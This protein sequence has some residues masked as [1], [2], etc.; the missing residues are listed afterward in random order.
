MLPATRLSFYTLESSDIRER[1]TTLA[2]LSGELAGRLPPSSR[3]ALSR[4]LEAINSYYSNMIEGQGTR[5][6]EAERALKRNLADRK[7]WKAMIW[8]RSLSP[9]SRPSA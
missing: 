9:K 3:I 8:R 6:I 2:R 7:P 5:P 4:C 1:E